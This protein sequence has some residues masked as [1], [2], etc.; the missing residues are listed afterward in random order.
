MKEKELYEPVSKWLYDF[1]KEKYPNRKI[2]T[3]DTSQV[4]LSD[5]IFDLKLTRY[6]PDYMS[7]EI[8][9]DVTG[10]AISDK[11]AD[12][13]LVECKLSKIGLKEI[14]QLLGYSIVTKPEYSF[15]ISPQGMSKA[16]SHLLLTL[17][18]YEILRY[19][20]GKLIRVCRWDVKKNDIVRPC[21]PPL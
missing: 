18:R 21:Y 5:L 11:K 4:Y 10:F 8:K 2:I 3:L 1:L 19:S 12:L 9:V 6:F 7:Y 13:A 15:I 14:S 16:V 20:E 17:K